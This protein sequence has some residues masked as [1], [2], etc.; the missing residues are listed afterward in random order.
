[1]NSIFKIIAAI[2]GNTL[3]LLVAD[4]FLDGMTL[5]GTITSILVVSIV[6]TFL[7]LLLKPILKIV[8]GPVIIATLGLA[9]V[10]VNII[11]LFLLDILFQ[12][13]SIHGITTL[14]YASLIVSVVN[15]I[16][17]AFARS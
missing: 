2:I 8:L 9:S 5:I 16:V 14:V 17:H 15:M 10:L 4:H 3:S 1:M 12:N 11:I 7:N 13:L 6:L